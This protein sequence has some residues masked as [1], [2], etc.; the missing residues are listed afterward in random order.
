[1]R[2]LPG[3][4]KS[5]YA[6]ALAGTVERSVICGADSFFEREVAT[7]PS[8]SPGGYRIEYV[9]DPTK[10]PEAHSRCMR[11][12]LRA[13]AI[14]VPLV[15]VDNTNIRRWEYQNYVLVARMAEYEVEVVEFRADTL[16]DVQTCIKRN[17]HGVPRDSVARMA[18]DFEPDP[19]SIVN[20]I[21]Q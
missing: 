10:L 17:T 14:Q 20:P 11:E 1:M 12:F 21:S 19:S 6:K 18:L 4:G 13:L 3:S 2:G 16:R 15:I 7:L 8:E 5:R 9:F